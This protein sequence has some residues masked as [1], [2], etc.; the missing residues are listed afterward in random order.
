MNSQRILGFNSLNICLD[1]NGFIVLIPH[2]V[3]VISV[4]RG[5]VGI[6]VDDVGIDRITLVNSHGIVIPCEAADRKASP[7]SAGACASHSTGLSLDLPD[8]IAFQPG[9]VQRS[10]TT[11][12]GPITIGDRAARKIIRRCACRV[13]GAVLIDNLN[14]YSAGTRRNKVVTGSRAVALL[15]P[16]GSG[17]CQ[18]SRNRQNFKI[19][20][21]QLM[22][23]SHID[24]LIVFGIDCPRAMPVA[25]LGEAGAVV[26]VI[27][28]FFV[29]LLFRSA[30]AAV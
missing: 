4:F 10:Y 23:R 24:P 17:D 12:A 29:G 3:S 25:N 9:K 18:F 20:R 26:S 21:Y 7:R 19:I 30:C 2:E 1:Q 28:A 15:A 6:V 5:I 8:L 13:R 11:A 14:G 22:V 27:I 16:V